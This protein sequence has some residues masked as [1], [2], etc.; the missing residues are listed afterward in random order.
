MNRFDVESGHLTNVRPPVAAQTSLNERQVHRS[1]ID[2]VEGLLR[3]QRRSK[4]QLNSSVG[5][6]SSEGFGEPMAHS[7]FVA[8]GEG[9]AIAV[10]SL[11]MEWD[12]ERQRQRPDADD[13]G[14]PFQDG[15]RQYRS[16]HSHRLYLFR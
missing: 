9:Q 6:F 11:H 16:R 10:L 15:P 4:V 12:V 14:E 1:A 2:P 7:Q 3:S 13:E 5:D 8:G